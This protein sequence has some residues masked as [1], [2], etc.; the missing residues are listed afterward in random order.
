MDFDQSPVVPYEYHQFQYIQLKVFISSSKG[1][2][3]CPWIS[4]GT[5]HEFDLS[6]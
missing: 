2:T 4:E 5:N 1:I 3:G 6:T